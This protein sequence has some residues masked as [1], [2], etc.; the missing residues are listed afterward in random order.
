MEYFRYVEDGENGLFKKKNSGGYTF[1]LQYKPTAYMVLSDNE[2]LPINKENFSSEEKEYGKFQFYTFR[3]QV[4]ADTQNFDML[5]HNLSSEDQYNNRLHY[6]ETGMQQDIKLI[7]GHD[8][9]NANFFLY[10]KEGDP[11]TCSSFLI[12]FPAPPDA[13]ED[14]TF[15]FDDRILK[16]G[17][18]TFTIN[19]SAIVNTPALNL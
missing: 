8:T 4:T 5:T 14:R 13:N 2:H 1:S 16:T 19:G 7:C 6:F 11:G 12:S 17:K 9:A 10:E 15:V 18:I 3:I